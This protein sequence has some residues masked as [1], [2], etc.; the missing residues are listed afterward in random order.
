MPYLCDLRIQ[1]VTFH[2]LDVISLSAYVFNDSFILLL[3]PS[4][5][6]KACLAEFDETVWTG[7]HDLVVS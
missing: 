1:R 3:I 5:V 6:V 4:D 2:D 7:V